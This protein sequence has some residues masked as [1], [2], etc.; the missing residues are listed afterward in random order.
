MTITFRIVNAVCGKDMDY[1]NYYVAIYDS[2]MLIKTNKLK[3]ISLNVYLDT[4]ESLFPIIVDTL[5]IYDDWKVVSRKKI[6]FNLN[7]I[8]EFYSFLNLFNDIIDNENENKY[9]IQNICELLQNS[10]NMVISQNVKKLNKEIPESKK[11]ENKSI[12]SESINLIK[13]INTKINETIAAETYIDKC[14]YENERIENDKKENNTKMDN[15]CDE[16]PDLDIEKIRKTIVNLEKTKEIVENAIQDFESEL[17]NDNDKLSEY[18]TILNEEEKKEKKIDEKIE[19]ELSI[20]ISEKEYTYKKIYNAMKKLGK[21]DFNKIPPLFMT[22]FPIFLFMDGKDCKGNN[23]RERLLDTDD[24]F[25]IY[26]LLYKTLT[27]ENIDETN[28]DYEDDIICEFINFLPNGFQAFTAEEIMENEN[29]KSDDP[30]HIIFKEKETEAEEIKGEENNSS[31]EK[32]DF[33]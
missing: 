8:A 26:T 21:I 15:I 30:N 18:T 20:Y 16:N 29:K 6:E 31:Y 14:D 9:V 24:E 33:M 23:V 7:I 12:V 1:F 27:E 11:S 19:K 13:N 10:S 32:R 4:H 2:L 17:N 5:V 28:T 3:N 25:K 22:K